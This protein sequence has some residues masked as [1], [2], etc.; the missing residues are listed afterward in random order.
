MSSSEQLARSR[1]LPLP[2]LFAVLP[3]LL[4]GCSINHYQPRHFEFVTVVKKP[5]SGSGGWRAAC[6]HVPIVNTA[7]WDT[8]FCKLGV[9]MPL[10]TKE[11][12]SIST[13]LAQRIAADCANEAGRVVLEF[14]NSPRPGLLCQE[15]K[16]TFHTILS[17]AVLGSRV[18]TQ[19][20]KETTPHV[21][22]F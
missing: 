2:L 6:L 12:G 19:C 16:S 10:A 18:M 21:I 3:P 1:A 13:A 11:N 17:R 9:E 5:K 4:A 22:E 8:Y 20:D 15:F 14:P 7:T